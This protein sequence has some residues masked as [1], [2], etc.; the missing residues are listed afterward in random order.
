MLSPA[1]LSYSVIT[2][3][4]FQYIV[5]RKKGIEQEIGQTSV[6]TQ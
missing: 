1:K 6:Q 5:H 4:K 3:A 2:L